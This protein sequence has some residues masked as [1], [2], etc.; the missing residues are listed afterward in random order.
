MIAYALKLNTFSK[1]KTYS[2]KEISMAVMVIKV[3]ALVEIVKA[4][5]NQDNK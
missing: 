1:W 5:D 3:D 4:Y 2:E